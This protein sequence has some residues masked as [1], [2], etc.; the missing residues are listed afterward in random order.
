MVPPGATGAEEKLELLKELKK[1]EEEEAKGATGPTGSLPCTKQGE[2]FCFASFFMLI[3]CY[4]LR[5]P[6]PHGLR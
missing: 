1:L 4:G 3:S 5:V 6:P 2:G